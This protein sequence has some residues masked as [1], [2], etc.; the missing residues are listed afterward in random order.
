MSRASQLSHA[1]GASHR[2]GSA[3]KPN[4]ASSSPWRTLST[5]SLL[6]GSWKFQLGSLGA[7]TPPLACPR[8]RCERDRTAALKFSGRC[9]DTTPG[10]A[11]SPRALHSAHDRAAHVGAY[12][13]SVTDT[14]ELNK[15]LVR[16]LFQQL[17]VIPSD[18]ELA[19]RTPK[20]D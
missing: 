14:L 11:D 18:D 4:I 1:V 12:D 2:A 3:T 6:A 8:N 5:R 17:G 10:G 15:V 9:V 7:M 19:A 20:Q 13:P 16:R